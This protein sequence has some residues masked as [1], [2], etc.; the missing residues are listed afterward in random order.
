MG[1]VSSVQARTTSNNR[2]LVIE[3]VGYFNMEIHAQFRKAYEDQ[4][5]RYERY[6]VNLQHCLGMDSAG[7]GMLLLLRDFAG[8]EKENL[9]ITQCPPELQNVLRYSSFDQIFTI[10]H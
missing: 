10:Q 4:D 3:V 5:Q 7:L 6:A 1:T 8:V 9:L 2:G